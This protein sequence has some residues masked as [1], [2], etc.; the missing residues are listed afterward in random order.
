MSRRQPGRPERYTSVARVYDLVSA[1]PVYRR[2]RRLAIPLLDLRPG[3]T[4]V[5]IGCGTGLNFPL[6][7]RAVGPDGLVVGVDASTQMLAQAH[8]RRLGD[9][10]PRVRLVHA[11]ATRLGADELVRIIG[12]RADAALATYSLSLM[13]DWRPAFDLALGAVRAGGRVGVVDMQ[14]P[15]WPC[16][17][18]GPSGHGCRRRRP[19]RPPLAGGRGD[20][21]RGRRTDR[22]DRSH[23]GAGGDP[24][25]VKVDRRSGLR[26]GSA[27]SRMPLRRQRQL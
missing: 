24:T 1:E 11:D 8:R 12:T 7:A 10:A 4:V 13:D 15:P 23:P 18:A 22:P 6:L 19:P 5:D 3:D 14:L 25:G 26:T 20:L 2:G 27:G 16:P 21:H 9:A 17:A